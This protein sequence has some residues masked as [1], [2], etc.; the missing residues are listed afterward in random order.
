MDATAGV[1]TI[2]KESSSFV[3]FISVICGTVTATVSVGT[4]AFAVEDFSSDFLTS[5]LNSSQLIPFNA[6]AIVTPDG[7]PPTETDPVVD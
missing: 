2:G 1:F 4:L 5:L 6:G 7:E 3:L